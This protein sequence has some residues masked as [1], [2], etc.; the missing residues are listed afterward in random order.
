MTDTR[1]FRTIV[2][3]RKTGRVRT[4]WAIH[5]KLHVKAAREFLRNL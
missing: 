5:P 4:F 2:I 1:T 3:D